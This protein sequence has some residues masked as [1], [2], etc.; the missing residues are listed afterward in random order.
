[1]LAGSVCSFLKPNW[2]SGM[3]FRLTTSSSRRVC[4]IFSAN[5]FTD[6]RRLIG[7]YSDASFRGFTRLWII[8]AVISSAEACSN[9]ARDCLCRSG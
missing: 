8:T 9:F 7:L 3:I 5:V 6:G 1:M 4:M 2:K